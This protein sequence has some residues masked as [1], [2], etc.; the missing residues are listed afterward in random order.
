MICQR[1]VLRTRQGP[2]IDMSLGTWQEHL[3]EPKFLVIGAQYWAM[4]SCEDC[5]RLENE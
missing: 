2:Q 5:G 4:G 1:D 3:L